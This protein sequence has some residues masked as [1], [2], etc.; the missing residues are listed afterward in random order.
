MSWTHYTNPIFA[1]KIKSWDGLG[2]G[3]IHR[4][5][6]IEYTSSSD[7]LQKTFTWGANQTITDFCTANGLTL[8]YGPGSATTNTNRSFTVKGPENV[9]LD[10]QTTET[11][12]SGLAALTNAVTHIHD[13]R[14]TDIYR[15]DTN[16]RMVLTDGSELFHDPDKEHLIINFNRPGEPSSGDNS[17]FYADL[18]IS[19]ATYN[20]GVELTDSGRTSYSQG[21]GLSFTADGL[22]NW[23]PRDVCFETDN[24]GLFKGRGG[25]IHCNK[26]INSL[27]QDIIKT[28][29]HGTRTQGSI[30]EWR[31]FTGVSFDGVVSNI[32]IM[33]I[34][35]SLNLVSLEINKG[36][37]S[38]LLGSFN[39]VTLR[40][41]DVSKNP[42]VVD[43][44]PDSPRDRGHRD[45]LII[46]SETGSDVIAMWRDQRS[47]NSQKGNVVTCKEVSF[48]VYDTTAQ[49]IEG[50]KMYLVDNPSDYAKDVTYT[51][52]STM[53]NTYHSYYSGTNGSNS[54]LS[55]SI[56]IV[57]TGFDAATITAGSGNT[58]N[59][60]TLIS[61]YN[62]DSGNTLDLT[63]TDGDGTQVPLKDIV[64]SG[65]PKPTLLT[66]IQFNDN[67]TISYNYVNPIEYE[68]TTDANGNVPTF[69]VVTSTQLKPFTANTES[70]EASAF[71]DNYN[72][73][74]RESDGAFPAFSDWD[75]DR[76]GGY[77]KVDRRSNSNSNLDDFTFNFCSY[78]HLLSNTTQNL[79]GI[80]EITFDWIL[81]EDALITETDRN[82]VDT[83]STIANSA[84][85]Y[86][87]A[88]SYL[89]DNYTGEQATIVTRSGIDIDAGSYDVVLDPNAS[90]AFAFNGS[91]ITI[92]A[93]TF[94]GNLTTTGTITVNSGVT[95][96]G[97]ITDVNNPAG[98][99]NRT[100]SIQNVILGTT[101]QIYNETQ[102]TTNGTNVLTTLKASGTK[103]NSTITGDGSSTFA[104]LVTLAGNGLEEDD[105]SD[106]N[107]VLPTGWSLVT[108]EV[109]NDSNRVTING[110]YV[111]GVEGSGD[112]QSGDSV[113][114]RATC[115]ASTGAFLPYVN[116]A[117]TNESGFSI[118]VVQ[119][120]DT[121]Y[122]DNGVDGSADNYDS[123]SLTITPDYSN[124]ELDVTDSDTDGQVTVQQIYAKYAYLITTTD[125]IEHFFGAMT[126]EN[127]TNYKINTNVVDLKI[128]NVGST[129][130][131]ITGARLYRDDSTTIIVKGP[132]NSGTLSHDTGEF[133]QFIGPQVETATSDIK[134]NTNLIPGLF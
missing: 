133:L 6:L 74:W 2:G 39:E 22:D 134:R 3:L 60:N 62:A 23:N 88:K 67:G 9:V 52:G 71:Y 83:Y 34:S 46:N 126:A 130:M 129:D 105:M 27:N 132:T 97:T 10:P 114:I 106:S 47:A 111:E 36:L 91:V 14:N 102:L 113:R 20:Y 55:S 84:Q 77:Y 51:A 25:V 59:L 43:I 33:G 49:P 5:Y 95:V 131:I 124:F 101:V 119:N 1:G 110:I 81:V 73:G 104:Q 69:Q 42:Y 29:F 90:T 78:H 32:S 115:A 75:T 54:G 117:I 82:V 64:L 87:R 58:K 86:D 40:D 18:Q 28:K 107:L 12:L 7:G 99:A 125:G 128:Q 16:C 123:L 56:T 80:G 53:K 57:S 89:T 37:I 61:E 79:K 50:C 65:K 116:T 120:V 19:G 103:T 85:F 109:T 70:T 63:L 98:L 72:N 31:W 76:F 17:R 24:G 112:F 108:E 11:D 118:R 30:Q 127:E 4:Y 122:N 94:T 96:L 15:L 26:A 38:E 8:R 92:H 44:G 68:K 100:F 93:T 13:T 48:N 66:N 21:C 45:Y 41:F 121:I 35:S